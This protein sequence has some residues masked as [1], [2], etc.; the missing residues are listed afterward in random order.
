MSSLYPPD[1][2]GHTGLH[3]SQTQDSAAIR[4]V[5][6][7]LHF[8]LI[9]FAISRSGNTEIRLFIQEAYKSP[10]LSTNVGGS[11]IASQ[12]TNRFI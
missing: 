12:R 7:I 9:F 8:I 3:D 4:R 5:T 2:Y 11:Q 1:I 6:L 10:T